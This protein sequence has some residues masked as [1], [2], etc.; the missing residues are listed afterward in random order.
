MAISSSMSLPGVEIQA[1][2]GEPAG[3]IPRSTRTVAS[4]PWTRKQRQRNR[5]PVDEYSSG[6]AE[7]SCSVEI[8]GGAWS[9]NR[10]PNASSP[11]TS[12]MLVTWCSPNILL[13]IAMPGLPPSPSRSGPHRG[14]MPAMAGSFY[15]GTSGFAYKEWKH[16]VFY[17]EGTK[18]KEMLAYYS[19]QL[20]S[21]EI[22][23]TFRRF[24]SEQTHLTW[25]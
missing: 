1:L 13:W 15:L 8:G 18:D 12:M 11:S 7:D 14:I 21:V 19:S 5:Q 23:Y 10:S 24:P 9:S 6:Y 22:N 3:P 17:P 4:G 25:K 20:S 16:D 2:A